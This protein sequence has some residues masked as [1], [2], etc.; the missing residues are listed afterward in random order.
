M[1]V[2]RLQQNRI[3]PLVLPII[4]AQELGFFDEFSVQVDLDLAE[5]F[6]FQ[7]KSAFLE[8]E[9]DAQ[10][11]DTTFFFYYLKDGKKAMITSTLTR[12]IQLAGTTDWQK[13]TP[14][15][16]GISQNGLF[17]FFIDTYL[18]E[19][20]PNVSY[21]FI[22]NT[23]ERIQAL[24]ACEIDALVAIE[25]FI[26]TVLNQP[27]TEI[28]WHSNQ[29]DACYVMW[30]FDADFVKNHPDDVR[31]FHQALEKAGQYFNQQTSLEKVALLETHCHLPKEKA[32]IFSDFEFEPQQNYSSSDFTLCQDWMHDQQ[33]ITEKITPEEG[34][35]H[36]F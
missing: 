22:N 10:M 26:T 19:L 9:V 7:G 5:N 31:H 27:N 34:V 24:M 15:T 11:G 23:Y 12:T 13:K 33:E 29:L 36:T 1:A 20:L 30:C 25:P 3:N 17:R 32:L 8:G 6:V 28:I 35:F 2:I 16:V 4:L 14:L 21:T 18:G